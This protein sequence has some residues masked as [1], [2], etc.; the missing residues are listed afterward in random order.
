MSRPALDCHAHLAPDVSA[1][2]VRGLGGALVFA[3]SRSLAESAW[4]LQRPPD[5]TLLWGLGVHPGSRK[6]IA[7]F[8]PE[9]FSR[10]L[11]H[12]ALVGEIGLDRRAGRLGVQQSILSEILSRVGAAP[13]ICSLHSAGC[14][15]EVVTLLRKNPVAAPVLHWFT[16]ASETV[17]EAKDLGCWFSVNSAMTDEQLERIPVS[18][19]LP[20]TDFPAGHARFPGDIGALERRLGS[21]WGRG[22]T[23]VRDCFFG[24]LGELSTTAAVADL[25]P[26]GVRQS[27]PVNPRCGGPHE[28]LQ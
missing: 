4:A 15:E 2:Q 1:E 8:D 9:I 28:S 27:L 12:F 20:E 18:R 19:A 26:L 14:P 25:L 24:N 16:G 21:I 6:A 5:P 11:P 3:V 23:D 7:D 17:A 10:L 13:A 22:P